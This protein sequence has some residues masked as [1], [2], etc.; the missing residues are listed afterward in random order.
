MERAD[1]MMEAEK[2]KTAAGE[3]GER[4]E[5]GI[6]R[7]GKVPLKISAVGPGD[8]AASFGHRDADSSV[9]H[10][11][12][13]FWRR[14]V[15]ATEAANHVMSKILDIDWAPHCQAENW[16]R[17]KTGRRGSLLR[18]ASQFLR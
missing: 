14:F 3:K 6:L 18:N 17:T 1:S 4:N 15:L 5:S 7:R 9:V 10:T 16:Y 8:G 13:A 12:C 11:G 2:R